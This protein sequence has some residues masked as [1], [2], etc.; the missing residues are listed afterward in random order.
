MARHHLNSKSLFRDEGEGGRSIGDIVS[1]E[2]I[3]RKV[4][5][6]TRE[7]KSSLPSYLY[8]FGFDIVPVFLKTSDYVLSDDTAI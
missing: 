7:F 3:R 4:L 2:E 8:H 5:V 1:G 6:D